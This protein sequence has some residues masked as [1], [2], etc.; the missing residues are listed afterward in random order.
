MLQGSKER[1]ITK[2]RKIENTKGKSEDGYADLIL[3]F[4]TA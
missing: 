4:L 2:A 1:I 3:N